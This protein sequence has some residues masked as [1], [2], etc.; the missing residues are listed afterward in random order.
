VA[1]PRLRLRIHTKGCRS[2]VLAGALEHGRE[3]HDPPGLVHL[4]IRHQCYAITGYGTAIY[5]GTGI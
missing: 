1:T 3:H 2:I 4:A 5:L